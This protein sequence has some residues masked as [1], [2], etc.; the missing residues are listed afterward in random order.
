MKKSYYVSK[1]EDKLLIKIAKLNEDLNVTKNFKEM[2]VS[3]RNH[4]NMKKI[5]V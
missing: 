4:F 3:I 1:I 5:H 2:R